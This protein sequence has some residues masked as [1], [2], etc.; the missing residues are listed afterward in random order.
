MNS[1]KMNTT[2][3]NTTGTLSR[4]P[5]ACRMA[6]AACAGAL[7]LACGQ[8]Q[9]IPEP[10][11]HAV[12]VPTVGADGYY[13]IGR[14]EHAARR[15]D[16]AQRAW[17]AAL[18]LDPRHAD[19]RNGLAVLLAERGNLGAAIALWRTLVEEATALPPA[20]QAFLLGNL[21]YA[22]HL[23]GNHGEAVTLLKKACLL[24]PHHPRA[25]DHLA[26]VFEALGQQDRALTMRKQARTLRMHDIRHDY[27]LTGARPPEAAAPAAPV[28]DPWP[29]SFAR[30]ELRQAG[31]VIEVHQ[32]A[33][34][35]EPAPPLLV[36]G[37]RED[38][39]DGHG[40]HAGLRL[41]ISNGNGARGMAAAWKHRLAGPE[42]Q[43]VRLTNEKPYAV[44]STRIEYRGES[45]A[46]VAA[47]A[48]AHRL[49]LL[50][51]RELADRGPIAGGAHVRIVLGWDQRGVSVTAGR[52][53]AQGALQAP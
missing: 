51:P 7:L 44:A 11:R 3:M 1:T 41:E 31:A 45:G 28:P 4:T 20:G 15:F 38:D 43:S 17:H 24:D 42:W 21:G 5:R 16:A 50:A 26:S 46:G 49:G 35:T 39:L 9:V 37:K 27:E 13:A 53:T 32:V 12:P 8:R 47:R 10:T 34:A 30:T 33:A 52:S 18:R 6:A 22:L 36:K 29:E 2:K 19:T 40:V 25:W 48:L 23:R 14:A